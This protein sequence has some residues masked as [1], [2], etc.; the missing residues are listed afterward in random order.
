MAF[1]IDEMM[2]VER[3]EQAIRDVRVP[4]LTGVQLFDVYRG[5]QIGPGKKSC[6]FALE[7]VAEDRTLTQEEVDD[8]M[9]KII[10]NVSRSCDAILRT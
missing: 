1:V 3:V 6:A 9:R 8:V 7:L 5:D 2:P 4:L 10:Q